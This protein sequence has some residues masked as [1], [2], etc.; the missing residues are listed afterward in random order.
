MEETASY[1]LINMSSSSIG[2]FDEVEAESWLGAAAVV[3]QF[4][5][6]WGGWVGVAI[7]SLILIDLY[8]Q[9]LGGPHSSLLIPTD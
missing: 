7:L 8:R 6:A 9:G 5:G 1:R 4:Q 3:A 2:S